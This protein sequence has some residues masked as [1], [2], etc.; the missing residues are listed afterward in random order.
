MF[1]VAA[2]AWMIKRAWDAFISWWSAR[3]ELFELCVGWKLG[4][5]GHCNR[6]K[7]DG[8]MAE[9]MVKFLEGRRN[10]R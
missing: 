8:S 10:G 7:A 6:R 4:L 2:G 5:C 1:F 3:M 9:F